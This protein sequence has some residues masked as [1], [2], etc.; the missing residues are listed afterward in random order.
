MLKEEKE[1]TLNDGQVLSYNFY[2]SLNEEDNWDVK[3]HVLY[4]EKDKLVGKEAIFDFVAN[5]NASL[6]IMKNG[7]HYFHTP[8]QLKYL[9]KWINEYL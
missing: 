4:G 5:H 7:A 1:I 3:T 6:T 9:K 2:L 8:G